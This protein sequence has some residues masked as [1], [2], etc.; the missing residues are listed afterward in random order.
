[1]DL[2]IFYYRL[3]RKN[4]L[5]TSGW[6]EVLSLSSK[7]SCLCFNFPNMF[8]AIKMI[9]N[10]TRL[11]SSSEIEFASSTAGITSMRSSCSIATSVEPEF[12][13][14]IPAKTFLKDFGFNIRLFKEHRL[15]QIHNKQMETKLPLAAISSCA[16]SKVMGGYCFLAIPFSFGFWNT[17]IWVDPNTIR[18]LWSKSVSPLIAAPFTRIR[19]SFVVGL[20]LTIF[21]VVSS[22]SIACSL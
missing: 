13:I 15:N 17:Q 21:F 18:S 16:Y 2:T 11:S 14:L 8:G 6:D 7:P 10:L 3:Y 12:S 1:M 22:F 9:S 5:L 20:I 19:H 4:L